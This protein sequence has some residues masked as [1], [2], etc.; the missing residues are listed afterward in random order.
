MSDQQR[1]DRLANVLYGLAAIKFAGIIFELLAAKHYDDPIQL[2]PF[3]LCGA[4]LILVLLAWR[5]PRRETVQLSRG[6][7]L[8]TAAASLLGVWKHVE[9][10]MGFVLELHPNA[11]GWELISGALTGQAPLLASG[12]LA[13]TGVIAITATFAA[14]WSLTGAIPA[15]ATRTATD[16]SLTPPLASR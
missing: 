7:M 12:A 15:G 5:R 13:V 14:G 1:L 4:G 9:G 11:T 16:R 3:A 2:I 8:V 6:F 10:N